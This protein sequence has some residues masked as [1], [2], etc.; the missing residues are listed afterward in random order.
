MIVERSARLGNELAPAGGLRAILQALP[1]RPQ[2]HAALCIV[3]ATEGSTYRKPGA[4]IL[5]D[6]AGR[7]EGWLSG[8]CLE[9]ELEHSAAQVI[10]SGEA[11]VFAIN[12]LS[13]D[14]RVFG[15]MSGCRGIIHLAILPLSGSS[16]L[17]L[18][19]RALGTATGNL[20]L[21]LDAHGAGAAEVD[22]QRWEWPGTVP[23]TSAR[24][25]MVTI[26]R[27]PRLMLLGAGP[28]TAPLLQLC[29]SVGWITHV[30][31]HRGRWA[32]MAAN[33]DSVSSAAPRD[34][35]FALE[36]ATFDAAIVMS[37]HIE[38]DRCYLSVLA[39]SVIPFVGLL[40]PPAR[41]A[42]LLD[43]LG[44]AKARALEPRLHGPVGLRLGGEG[45]E[46]IALAIVAAL[47]Q[48]RSGVSG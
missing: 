25:W 23:G 12:T 4:L 2:Q 39:D 17:T 42:M 41:R 26:A 31:E 37:H 15:S 35:A 1:E 18:A 38:H 47:A 3:V 48:F 19:L 34:C 24:Q 32:A 28:E 40:G 36:V 29:R 9:A 46:A 45:P 33:A 7:R 43:E 13:D 30:V 16:P 6:A 14:D 21:Q 5:V 20:S 10:A 44:E 27:P 11:R 22:G 8:G